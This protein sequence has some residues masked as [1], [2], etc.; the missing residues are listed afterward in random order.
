L[1]H[2]ST[3]IALF[4]R[5][6]DNTSV[7][8][9]ATTVGNEIELSAEADLDASPNNCPARTACRVTFTACL[10]DGLNP[11]T[12]YKCQA[13]VRAFY[14]WRRNATCVPDYRSHDSAWKQV[15]V[16]EPGNFFRF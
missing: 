7:D 5:N 3:N 4:Q 10:V 12:E 1:D 14:D 16:L 11:G 13:R 8:W 15:G 6:P 2:P 9:M